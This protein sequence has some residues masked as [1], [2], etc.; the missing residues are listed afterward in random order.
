MRRE[1]EVSKLS[2]NGLV[3]IAMEKCKWFWQMIVICP[4]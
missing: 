1:R 2:H 4:K 3:S